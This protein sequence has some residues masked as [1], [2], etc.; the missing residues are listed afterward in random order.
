M[1]RNL[2]KTKTAIGIEVAV[3]SILLMSVV[4]DPAL[5]ILSRRAGPTGKQDIEDIRTAIKG[6]LTL[7]GVG[8]GGVGLIGRA[9]AKGQVFTPKF[10]PG[11]N[12]S[13]L[14]KQIIEESSQ[15]PVEIAK[16]KLNEW[17]FLN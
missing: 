5:N 15:S 10:L 16:N 4:V 12:K 9:S 2:F 8:G 7:V 11:P 6:V 17:D 1:M 3:G 14:I 13:D